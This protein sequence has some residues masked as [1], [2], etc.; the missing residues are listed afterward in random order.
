[1]LSLG[2]LVEV[3]SNL[4]SSV[5]DVQQGLDG[6]WAQLEELHTGVTLSKKGDQ[7]PRELTSAQADVKVIHVQC[8]TKPLEWI[9]LYWQLRL[10]SLYGTLCYNNIFIA[11]SYITHS[12]LLFQNCNV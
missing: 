5:G 6:L 2:E 7:G 8:P 12:Y 9:V 4:E 3:Q 11:M 10:G 1:M